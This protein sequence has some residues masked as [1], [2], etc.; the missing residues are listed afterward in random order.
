MLSIKE[1]LKATKGRLV[2]PGANQEVKGYSID[3]R[4]IKRGEAFIAISGNN[5]DGHDFIKDAVKKGASCIIASKVPEGKI[6][7]AVAFIKVKNTQEALAGIATATRIKYGVPVIA[8]TG[9]AGKTTVKDMLAWIL[10]AE[11]NVLSNEGTKNNHI[12]LPLTLCG[13]NK[14]HDIAV[15]ELGTNHFGEIKNLARIC[16]PNI[17]IITNI[18]PAHLEYFK[19]LEGVFKE[20]ASL[21]NNLRSPGL[22]VLNADDALLREKLSGRCLKPFTL[23]FAVDHPADFFISDIKHTARGIKFLLNRKHKFHLN[24]AGSSNVYNAAAAIAVARVFGMEYK[25][26]CRRLAGFKFPSG[27]LSLRLANGVRII[28]DTYNS[29]PLSLRQALDALEKLKTCGRK[30]FVMGDMLELGKSKQTFHREAGFNAA[31]ICD[32]FITVGKLSRLAAQEARYSGLQA[33][34]IFTCGS[35]AEACNILKNKILLKDGDI[36]LAKGSRAMKMEEALNAI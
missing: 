31:R 15:L 22:A 16:L 2:F 11:F 5:F 34:N 26:I 17:G 13:L 8:V 12:G 3:S 1:I 23:S 24:S 27:R 7:P 14:C 36:V 28:D 30:I 6:P 19:G 4:K 33:E 18:G 32:I 35:A 25:T 21:I 10:S 29:N 20:K 9:S